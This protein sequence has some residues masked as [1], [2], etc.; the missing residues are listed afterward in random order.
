MRKVV[1]AKRIELP[2]Y[3]V[4]VQD[5]ACTEILARRESAIKLGI[6]DE[7]GKRLS[8]SLPPDMKE[9]SQSEV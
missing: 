8:T 2:A 9:S 4:K 6:I 3:W 7:T 1:L 5:P